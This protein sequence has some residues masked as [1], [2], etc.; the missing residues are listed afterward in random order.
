MADVFVSYAS[1]DRDRVRPLVEALQARGLSVWWDRDLVA[2]PSFDRDIEAAL[3]AA[4]CVVVVW[5]GASGES[6]WCRAEASEGM[7]RGIL[8]PLAI[9]PVTPPLA[10]RNAQTA[11]MHGWPTDDGGLRS[12]LEGIERILG[13]SASTTPIEDS[14]D[15][16]RPAASGALRSPGLV[17]RAALFALVLLMGVVAVTALRT[18]SSADD[19]FPSEEPKSAAGAVAEGDA[20]P[21]PE[22]R[23]VA[24]V[25]LEDLTPGG[26]FA[27]L[28]SGVSA[29]VRRQ[30]G[31]L[32]DTWVVPASL[33][34]SGRLDAL[35]PETTHLISGDLRVIDGGLAASVE[36][37]APGSAASL[38]AETF[39]ARLDEPAALEGRLATSITRFFMRSEADLGFF[40]AGPRAPAARVPYLKFLHYAGGGDLDEERRWLQRTVDADPA[41][42]EGWMVLAFG[43][44]VEAGMRADPALLDEAGRQIDRAE[45]LGADTRWIRLGIEWKRNGDLDR[46]EG[47]FR[48]TLLAMP[49]LQLAYAKLLL[50]SGLT[51]SA[52][53]FYEV[54]L[55]RNP[56]SGEWESLAVACLLEDD[57]ACVD[58]ALS[59]QRRLHGD[60]SDRMD[61]VRS[62]HL[63]RIGR[64]AEARTLL[65]ELAAERDALD[66][67][68]R[69]WRIIDNVHR[70]L[71]MT[72]A[73]AEGEFEVLRDRLPE[74][75]RRGETGALHLAIS[76]GDDE[77]AMEEARRL[78]DDPDAVARLAT[79][80]W[81]WQRAL[82]PAA[83]R[84]HPAFELVS[85][86]LGYDAAWRRE[87]CSRVAQIP[88]STGFRCDSERLSAYP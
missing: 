41:W 52:R 87:L 76:L 72:L 44:F 14:S 55:E 49:E 16:A 1:Q 32:D 11:A 79:L 43:N 24:V 69:Q 12:V 53:N 20:A 82:L 6:N 60:H 58:R 48:E 31:R 19:E 3:A 25:D 67:D 88:P 68:G 4:R 37:V 83:S 28:A 65:S 59:A 64:L 26:E 71:S 63:P 21:A 35:P 22:R 56:A 75:R 80:S 73:R 62:I 7:G 5:S 10:F 9:D 33:A 78:V 77:L 42:A 61:L 38:W 36:I 50:E 57:V 13:E 34:R 46:I 66:P 45:A 23:L 17:A 70:M 51:A 54:F 27:W 74:A 8:V 47:A 30:I 81:D 39:E 2:G 15:P 85:A 18:G 84:E 86:S 29:V 40:G